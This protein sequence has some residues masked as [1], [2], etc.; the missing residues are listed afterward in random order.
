MKRKAGC[1]RGTQSSL[2]LRTKGPE[3]QSTGNSNTLGY[4]RG[5]RVTMQEAHADPDI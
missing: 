4:S 1:G 5:G 2:T 3:K